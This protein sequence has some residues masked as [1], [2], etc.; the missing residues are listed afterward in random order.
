M[1]LAFIKRNRVSYYYNNI[2]SPQF[3]NNLFQ[4]LSNEPNVISN[5]KNISGFIEM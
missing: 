3:E 2:D 4:L 5:Y 1:T